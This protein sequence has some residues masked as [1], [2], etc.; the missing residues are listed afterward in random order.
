MQGIEGLR[1]NGPH[2]GKDAAFELPAD[3]SRQLVRVHR[4][5]VVGEQLELEQP[6]GVVV[7][8]FQGVLHRSELVLVVAVPHAEESPDGNLQTVE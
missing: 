8:P 2:Q 3:D 7:L 6:L 5:D 4:L 1:V